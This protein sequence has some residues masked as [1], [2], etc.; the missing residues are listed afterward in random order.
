MNW[1]DIEISDDNTHYLFEGKPVFN[2]QFIEV[3]KFHESG[4]APV[5]DETGAYHIDTSGKQLYSER[6]S[7]T[8]GYYCNRAAVVDKDQWYH[9]TKSGDKAYTC[10]YSWAGN[11]QE[12]F[13][14]VRDH[15]NRYFHID[16]YGQNIYTETFIYCGDYKDSIACVKTANG[17]YK[18]IDT[19]GKFINSKEFHDLGVFHKSFATAKEKDGW[20]HI[21]KGG[22]EIYKQRYLSVEPFYNGFALVTQFDNSKIIIDERGQKKINI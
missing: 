1:Q 21:D 2:K 20:Y 4:I 14:T 16:L 6:F 3:L 8:F 5:K 10:L 13:C 19:K 11:Y 7:R 15:N 12:N 9:I 18:H 22:K 17:F